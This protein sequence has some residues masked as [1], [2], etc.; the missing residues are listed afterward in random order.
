M[1]PS[2]SLFVALAWLCLGGCGRPSNPA[3]EAWEKVCHAHEQVEIVDPSRRATEIA[4]WIE[5]NVSE[6]S[7]REAFARAGQTQGDKGQVLREAAGRAGVSDCPVLA[8]MW[9]SP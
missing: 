5:A 7:V 2:R 6:P 3:K 1:R 4:R 9:S 8:V